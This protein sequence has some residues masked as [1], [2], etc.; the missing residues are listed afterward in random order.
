[1]LWFLVWGCSE[2]SM[3]EV[4][5]EAP[6]IDPSQEGGWIVATRDDV[7]LNRHGQ[8]LNIQFWYPTEEEKSI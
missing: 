3:D 8:E 6:S 2:K 5:E 7:F 4:I 1:M